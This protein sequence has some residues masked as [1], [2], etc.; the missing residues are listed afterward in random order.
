MA[1]KNDRISVTA[2]ENIEKAVRVPAAE[3][4]WHGET[5]I[6]KPMLSLSEAAAFVRKV[7]SDCFNPDTGEYQPE[8][9]AFATKRCMVALYTNLTL[10]KNNEAQYQ[11]IY[12]TDIIEVIC[13]CINQAQYEEIERAI[14][15]RI[16]VILDAAIGDVKERLESAV[17]SI[18][19]VAE[20]LG[21]VFGGID[22]EDVEALARALADG[23]FDSG[24]LMQ[25]YLGQ[26]QEQ[27]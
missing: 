18:Q 11:L 21:A 15:E 6:V 13:T 16:E 20:S 24:K 1:K 5:L 8:A 26:K 2:F 22:R 27:Q 7:T 3:V 25:A 19:T 14:E 17:S 23:S 4:D 12:G 9:K 10:P